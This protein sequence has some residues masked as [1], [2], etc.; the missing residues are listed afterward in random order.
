MNQVS[1]AAQ[2]NQ[3]SARGLSIEAIDVVQPRYAQA[4]ASVSHDERAVD[5]DLETHALQSAHHFDG[6]VVTQ[7]RQARSAHTNSGQRF[8]QQAGR[9]ID[10]RTVVTADVAGQGE[11]VDL[12]A[13]QQR[14]R[15]V[16]ELG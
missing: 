12:E 11:H 8:H 5:E 6:V 2:R 13:N 15:S 7:H 9:S 1:T 3:R 10:R 16:N 4:V 14:P